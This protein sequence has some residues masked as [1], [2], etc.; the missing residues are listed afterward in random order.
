M[1]ESLVVESVDGRDDLGGVDATVRLRERAEFGE[2]IKEIA[3]GAEV[4]REGKKE[5]GEEEN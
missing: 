4:L 1:K 3:T 2:E 5:S